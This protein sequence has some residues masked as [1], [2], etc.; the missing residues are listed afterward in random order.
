[1]PQ[2]A[3]AFHDYPADLLRLI[4]ITGTL[5]KTSTTLLLGDILEA[6][7]KPV[8]VVGSLGIKLAEATQETGITTP[9]ASILQEALRWFADQ[10][11]GHVAME[12]TSHALSQKRIDGCSSASGCSPTWFPTSIS[13][14][15]RRRST[16]SRPR[17]AS[18]ISSS[19]AAPLVIN[20][21]CA[22]PALAPAT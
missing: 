22:S 12:V 19:R 6:D 4:G 8:G 2:L 7:R 13:N 21:D 5:G 3:A 20:A 14:T 10:G 11:V 18:S 17:C 1:L 15:T 16:I 9:D